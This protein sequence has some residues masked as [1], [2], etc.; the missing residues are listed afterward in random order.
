[1]PISL[2]VKTLDSRN[3]EFKSLDESMTVREL[4]AHIAPTVAIAAESQRLI[5]SGRVLQVKPLC[6]LVISA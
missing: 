4:K 2:T 5:Y 1:M 6:I 3:H